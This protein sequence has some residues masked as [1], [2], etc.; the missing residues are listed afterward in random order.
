MFY[1]TEDMAHSI[2]IN[3]LSLIELKTRTRPVSDWL[4]SCQ[5]L[6]RSHAELGVLI[7]KC[8]PCVLI[9]TRS[10]AWFQPLHLHSARGS[11]LGGQSQESEHLLDAA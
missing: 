8:T 10:L 4:L 3:V 5:S 6:I 7:C 9:R 1:C 2:D 11:R